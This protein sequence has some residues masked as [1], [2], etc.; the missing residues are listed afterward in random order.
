MQIIRSRR[1]TLALYIQPDGQ[2]LVRAPFRLPQSTIEAFV[3]DKAAWIRAKQDEIRRRSERCGRPAGMPHRFEQGE[4]F[5]YLGESYPLVIVE[6]QS[7][8]VLFERTFKLKRAAQHQAQGTFENW[9]KA[10]AQV[11]FIRRL[12][13]LATQTDLH[14]AHLRLSNARTRWGSCS[15]TGTISLNWRL[16]MASVPVIDYVII[17]ELAHLKEKNH[18]ARYWTLVEQLLPSYRPLRQWLKANGG[19][20]SWP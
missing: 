5:L 9:Y 20:L 16:V 18:S 3:Q 13:E 14:Y 11:F 10:Q 12:N 19:C 4:R 6:R 2:V 15:P 7:Q 8:P 17:H 1:K